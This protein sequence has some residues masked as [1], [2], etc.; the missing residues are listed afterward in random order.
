MVNMGFDKAIV[1]MALRT[2]AN[3]MDDAIEMLLKYQNDGTYT[4]TLQNIA[5]A[6]SL[7]NGD[8]FDVAGPST[9]GNN[10]LEKMKKS[11]AAA[12]EV[13]FIKELS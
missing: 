5:D 3:N 9:S 10:D 1:D 4:E 13:I 6:V 7:T 2:V 12:D 11:K 8:N